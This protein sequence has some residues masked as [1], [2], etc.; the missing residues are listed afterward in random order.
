MANKNHPYSCTPV[1]SFNQLAR[2]FAALL[3][4]LACEHHM[5]G[6]HLIVV[7]TSVMLNWEMEFK[8]W[9]PA[10]KILTYYGN[11]KERKQK[12]T[13]RRMSEE[14]ISYLKLE[15]Q[16]RQKLGFPSRCYFCS[17]NENKRRMK[18]TWR[19]VN[20][21]DKN[22]LAIFHCVHVELSL[23]HPG[24]TLSA[25]HC[26]VLPAR[27]SL[28]PKRVSKGWFPSRNLCGVAGEKYTVTKSI[29]L[30]GFPFPYASPFQCHTIAFP[31]PITGI[32][33]PRRA[34]R[35]RMPST[36]ASRPTNW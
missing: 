35:R 6:P 5:W 34:G 7:P 33:S 31:Y 14:K 3:A 12:R 8:K 17:W 28:S 9:A 27:I 1:F 18:S 16:L 10:F 11:Q 23:V 36:C 32:V 30:E 26:L 22:K 19:N 20:R 24:S 13:V 15:A 2:V 29:N 25:V 4:H 21:H